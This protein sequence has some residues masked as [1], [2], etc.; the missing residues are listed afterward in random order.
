MTGQ[1]SL[2]TERS[3]AWIPAETCLAEWKGVTV[4][5]KAGQ[6]GRDYCVWEV[7]QKSDQARKRGSLVLEDV[8]LGTGSLPQGASQ[9]SKV[10]ATFS[11]S[12]VSSVVFLELGFALKPTRGTFFFGSG[13]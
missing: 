9:R 4:G 8:G 13:T 6:E 1:R 10:S 12:C 3:R 2:T 5:G 11:I 7:S